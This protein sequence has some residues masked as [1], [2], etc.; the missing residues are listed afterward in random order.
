MVWG[1]NRLLF[2]LK[3]RINSLTGYLVLQ[4]CGNLVLAVGGEL[5]LVISK[6]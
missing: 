4:L 3:D 2:T 5:V 6:K 1:S